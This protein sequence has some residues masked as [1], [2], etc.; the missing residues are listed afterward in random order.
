MPEPLTLHA[1]CFKAAGGMTADGMKKLLG[2]PALSLL[3]TVIR[4]TVQNS[5]DARREDFGVGYRIRPRELRP[6]ELAVL[7]EEVF[8]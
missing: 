5:W 2:T 7:E 3:E 1:E 4:E 8:D 6:K